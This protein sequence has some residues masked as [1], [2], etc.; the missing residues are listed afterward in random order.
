MDEEYPTTEPFEIEML[1]GFDVSGNYLEKY[2]TYRPVGIPLLALLQVIM[3][4]AYS[5]PP[6]ALR[7]P[8]GGPQ[9]CIFRAV[10]KD[11]TDARAEFWR[12]SC[13][14]WNHSG[15]MHLGT[16]VATMLIT[17][18]P[19]EMVHGWRISC[20]FQLGVVIGNLT[21]VMGNPWKGLVGSSGGVYAI[22]G[23]H[24][25]NVIVNGDIMPLRYFRMLA[26][27]VFVAADLCAYG[28][29]H[30]EK[31]AYLAHVGGFLTGGT[32]GLSILTNFE[33]Q[34]WEGIVAAVGTVCLG[35][36][37]LI[38]MIWYVG[39]MDPPRALFQEVDPIARCIQT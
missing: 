1:P 38:C 32:A 29:Q 23:T 12:L 25:S 8:V 19:L 26:L 35:T 18:V 10:H 15:L 6:Y 31:V 20:I 9:A 21:N 27:L 11:C 13:S 22:I 33:Q 28:L 14:Q 37:T 34:R 2:K 3:F 39:Y 7:S 5:D 4:F 17:G 24:L 16:N 30:N 36:W